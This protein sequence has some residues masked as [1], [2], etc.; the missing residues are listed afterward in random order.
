V[1]I[2][3]ETQEQIQKKKITSRQH[4]ACSWGGVFDERK[5]CV[6]SHQKENCFA[7][8]QQKKGTTKEFRKLIY[9]N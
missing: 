7:T 6:L 9:W 5:L 4:N 8:C 1:G 2:V 3:G